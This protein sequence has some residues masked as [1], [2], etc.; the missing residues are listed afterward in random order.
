MTTCVGLRYGHRAISA[1]KIFLEACLG[2]LSAC[3]RARGTVRFGTPQLLTAAYTYTLQPR[4]PSRGGPFTPSS[5][6]CNARRGWNVDQLS[7][8]LASRLTLRPRLTLIRLAL[9]RKPRSIGVGVSRPH[10]RY[11]CLHLLFQLLHR[12]SRPGFCAAGMLP[13]H[14]ST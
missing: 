13:Y 6:R 2:P 14:S 4:I 9:I 11:S 12:A 7:I 5:L 1:M 10:Y 8:E 3:P